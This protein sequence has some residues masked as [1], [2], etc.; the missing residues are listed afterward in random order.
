MEQ[1]N[2]EHEEQ[3]KNYDQKTNNFDYAYYSNK[4]TVFFSNLITKI[5]WNMMIFYSFIQIKAELYTKKALISSKPFIE[6]GINKIVD[7]Y[8]YF[9]GYKEYENLMERIGGYESPSEDNDKLDISELLS[10]LTHNNIIETNETN[11]NEGGDDGD[12]GDGDDGDG[13]DGDG[14]DGD[15]DGDGDGDDGDGDDGD[16]GDDDNKTMNS[17]D[18]ELMPNEEETKKMK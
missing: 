1:N 14:D 15:G 8:R 13:D 4:L 12:D 2:M 11:E 16:G 10:G 7:C 17:N 18:V 3:C 5:S 6:H 9:F